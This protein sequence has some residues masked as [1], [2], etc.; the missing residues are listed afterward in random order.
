MARMN[1]EHTTRDG[2]RVK[3][4]DTV[5]APDGSAWT[6]RSDMTVGACVYAEAAD[7]YAYRNLEAHECYGSREAAR[8]N[9]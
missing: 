7:G 9:A 2:R 3:A 1:M 5:Y 6:V 4:G 8:G